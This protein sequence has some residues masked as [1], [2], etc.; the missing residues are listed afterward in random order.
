MRVATGWAQKVI[1][2]L[3]LVGREIISD[4]VDRRPRWLEATIWAEVDDSCWCGVE[5]SCQGFLRWI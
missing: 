4:D 3:V 1:D 5:P 2:G